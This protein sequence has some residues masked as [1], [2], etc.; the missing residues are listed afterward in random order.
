MDIFIYFFD[1]GRQTVADWDLGSA[2]GKR[3]ELL[4]ETIL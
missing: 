4:V 2:L 3:P 1:K